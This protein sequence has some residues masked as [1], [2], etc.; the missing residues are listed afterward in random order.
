MLLL[1]F[2]LILNVSIIS[3]VMNLLVDIKSLLNKIYSVF[4]AKAK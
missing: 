1:Y 2:L 4:N 3:L